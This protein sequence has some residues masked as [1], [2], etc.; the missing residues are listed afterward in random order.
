MEGMNW[1]FMF[2]PPSEREIDYFPIEDKGEKC[3]FCEKF[4]AIVKVAQQLKFGGWGAYEKMCSG[5]AYTQHGIEVSPSK[6]DDGDF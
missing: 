5:C 1:D 3:Q 6:F 4:H 2:D